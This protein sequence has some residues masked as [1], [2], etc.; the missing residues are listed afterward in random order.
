MTDNN[1]RRLPL[2]ELVKV[3]ADYRS[4]TKILQTK[5]AE[6]FNQFMEQV[7]SQTPLKSGIVFLKQ[8]NHSV[9]LFYK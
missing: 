4:P 3:E 1:T 2:N 7:Q 8:S 6:S 5:Y 9:K